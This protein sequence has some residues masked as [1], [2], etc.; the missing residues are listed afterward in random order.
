MVT[1]NVVPARRPGPVRLDRNAPPPEAGWRPSQDH[2]R[3][4]ATVWIAGC[5]LVAVVIGAMALLFD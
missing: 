4:G 2:E 5:A 3:L 1:R